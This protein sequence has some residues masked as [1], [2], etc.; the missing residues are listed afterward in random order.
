MV[1]VHRYYLGLKCP[2]GKRVVAPLDSCRRQAKLRLQG[3]V[4]HPT[5]D[6]NLPNLCS[7]TFERTPLADALVAAYRRTNDSYV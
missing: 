6:R 3:C 2:G 4:G 7:V 1:T 5:P